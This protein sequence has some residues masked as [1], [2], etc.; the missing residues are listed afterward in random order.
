MP[1]TPLGVTGNSDT[2]GNLSTS[3]GAS[4]QYTGGGSG[5][6]YQSNFQN[7]RNVVIVPGKV[8][9]LSR[10]VGYS[11]RHLSFSVWLLGGYYPM[12]A[13]AITNRLPVSMH[14]KDIDPQALWQV[15]LGEETFKTGLPVTFEFAPGLIWVGPG[16]KLYIVVYD[17][18]HYDTEAE[19][20][21]QWAINILWEPYGL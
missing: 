20:S 6:T 12:T 4:S 16:E 3:G 11:L 15:L 7:D 18:V 5:G 1:I 9:E 2:Q 19:G 14:P 13:L 21:G 10:W 8:Y 17:L